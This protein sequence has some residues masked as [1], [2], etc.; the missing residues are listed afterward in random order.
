MDK[1][2][3]QI[4]TGLERNFGFANVKNGYTDPETGKLKLKNGALIV[5]D[6]E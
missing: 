3:I 4:F 2:F 1:K 6:H 5:I